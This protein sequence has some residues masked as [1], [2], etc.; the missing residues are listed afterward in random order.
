MGIIDYSHSQLNMLIGLRM[1]FSLNVQH[2]L[3]IFKLIGNFL[4]NY[5]SFPKLDLKPL[6]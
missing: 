5:T 4:N 1:L 6:N 2:K 3:I